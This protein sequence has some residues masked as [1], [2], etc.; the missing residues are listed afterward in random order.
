MTKGDS[1]EKRY[2]DRV[3]VQFVKHIYALD[4]MLESLRK[5][6]DNTPEQKQTD[7]MRKQ[8]DLLIRDGWGR[9]RDEDEDE[10]LDE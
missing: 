8:L 5:I 4:I 1:E 3:D 2:A 7:I 6:T 9:I 10:T